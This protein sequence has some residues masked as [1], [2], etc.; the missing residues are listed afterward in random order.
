MNL[1]VQD[2]RGGMS[3][4]QNERVAYWI[5][6]KVGIPWS[7]IRYA[8]VLCNQTDHGLYGDVQKVDIEY[9]GYWFPGDDEG[10]LYKI[11]DW[12]EFNDQWSFS[13]R[14]AD[15]R[16]WQGGNL[17]GWGEEKELYRWNYHVRSRDEEDNFQP[18]VNLI[19]KM[20]PAM[21]PSTPQYRA[22][23]EAVLDVGEA[24]K[25]IGV[26]HTVGD[27]DSWGY[28]R[29]KNNLLYQRPSDGRFVL[30]P[31]DIDFVLGS[32]DGPSTSLTYTNDQYGFDQ[33]FRALGPE[34]EQA[35]W[36]IVDGP[37]TPGAANDYID[38]TH[39]L[40]SQEGLGVGSPDS[41]KSF[42]ASRR[43]YLLQILDKPVS[44][45]TND[46]N[47]V[48]TSDAD[49]PISGTAPFNAESMTL[50][51]QPIE[52]EWT[53]GTTWVLRG[54]LSPGVNYL[55]VELFDG[56][57]QS[58]GIAQI[59]VTLNPFI[60]QQLI[61]TMEGLFLVWNSTPGESYTILAGNTPT[62]LTAI[63]PTLEAT[64]PVSYYIDG[65]AALHARRF[66]RVKVGEPPLLP[67]LEA[68]YFSGTNFG[69]LLASRID[70]NVDFDWGEG[71]PASK[72]P[73]DGFSV[74]WT[75][76]I[77]AENPGL[78]TFWTESND[79]VR[80]TVAGETVI[81]NWTDHSVIL[82]EGNISLSQGIHP[83]V[84]EY[85]DKTGD[86]VIRLHYQAPGIPQQIIPPGVL[87][88]AP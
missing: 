33:F 54:V 23:I 36:A 21:N 6:R 43:N 52:P 2:P 53:S 40:L 73:A 9:L 16:Y 48:V 51:G 18:L 22:G 68:E 45:T 3:S 75:G 57:S 86:A 41:I 17:G 42:L 44:I 47:S 74:R 38:R 83:I 24:L 50:N 88:R 11:D 56:N 76:F 28:R 27:W 19:S 62:A 46:G 49:Y 70:D 13:Y 26:R 61:Y 29:G 4:L 32:G 71:P 77:I 7:Q 79:G 31:W 60:I 14:T 65:D 67:G 1:D 63:S 72:V 55:T 10:Y 20:D 80:L 8:R 25:E 84:L 12:F 30:I 39:Q 66:Y 64:S 59:T 69:S 15:L 78:H 85:Y 58:L 5:C 81:E 82:D 35:L 34:Y 37:L 87:G